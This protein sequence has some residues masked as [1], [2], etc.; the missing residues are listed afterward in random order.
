MDNQSKQLVETFIQDLFTRGDQDAV[1]RYL[2][3][4][5]VNHDPPF[6]PAPSRANALARSDPKPAAAWSATGISPNAS[7]P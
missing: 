2:D 3:P 7:R 5:F 4:Q 6:R 1:D